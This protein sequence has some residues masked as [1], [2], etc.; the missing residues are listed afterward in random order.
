[1]KE[2]LRVQQEGANVG[3]KADVSM[4][5]Y[6]TERLSAIQETIGVITI[7]RTVGGI[8]ISLIS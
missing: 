3:Q 6:N 7:S 4:E 8:L 5:S 2:V 1:M